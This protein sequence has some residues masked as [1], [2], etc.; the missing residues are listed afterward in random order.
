MAI[1]ALD[2]AARV[3]LPARSVQPHI[4]VGRRGEEDAYFYLRSHGYCMVARNYRSPRR[5][6]EIDLIGW[7]DGLLCFI[8]VKTR[9]S[10]DVKPAEAA[11]NRAKREEIVNVARQYLRRMPARTPTRC[12]IVTVYYQHE[13]PTPQIT[14]FKNAFPMG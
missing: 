7:D 11:V 4:A 9:S 6:G 3:A 2:A 12:D 13:R 10:H 1:R 8:E 14:L 5:P